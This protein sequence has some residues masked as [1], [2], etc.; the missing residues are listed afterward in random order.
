MT[1]L[2]TSATGTQIEV[3]SKRNVRFGYRDLE[4]PS[5]ELG[6][7][8]DSNSKLGDYDALQKRLD[9]DGYLLLRG[10]LDRDEILKVRNLLLSYM[11]D[12]GA[13]T[14]GRPVLE[15]V[16][17]KDGKSV[18]IMG[19][20][21][22]TH[23]PLM[24][25][26]LESPKLFRLYEGLF[27]EN[28]L[29]YDY[30]WLRAVGREKYTSAHCDIVYMGRG[31]QQVL[32]T[33]IPFGDATVENSTLAICVG[34]HDSPAFARVRQTYGKMDVDRDRTEGWFTADPMEI[35]EQFGGQW[36]TTDFYAGDIL[37]FGMFTMHA[38]TTNMTNRYRISADVR[39]QPASAS[40]D[41]RWYGNLRTG[42]SVF[43]REPL[44]SIEEARRAW[45]LI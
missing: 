8:R 33:W 14:P 7:L 17:P 27:G 2:Q 1:P 35:V 29:T 44:R 26:V 20:E 36:Q 10:F 28:C 23:H 42:H 9:G 15:G 39:Y 12:R 40:V 38:S 5:V 11:G 19:N 21:A 30:K 25:N 31:S 4:F 13:L 6:E 22:V 37:L 24:L 43:G 16:M 45:G 32:T 3:H 18:R 34:S 41:D